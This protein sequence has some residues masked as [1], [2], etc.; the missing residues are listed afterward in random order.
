MD[1]ACLSSC[2]RRRVPNFHRTYDDDDDDDY[3]SLVVA[4]TAELFRLLRPLRAGEWE[5]DNDA[6]NSIWKCP[7]QVKLAWVDVVST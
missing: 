5:S 1:V 6:K 4:V 7:I 2:S 3:G